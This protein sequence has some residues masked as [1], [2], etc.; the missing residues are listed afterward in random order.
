MSPNLLLLSAVLITCTFKGWAANPQ[1]SVLVSSTPVEEAVLTTPIPGFENHPDAFHSI[2]RKVFTDAGNSYR[3]NEIHFGAFPNVAQALWAQECLKELGYNPEGV[4]RFTSLPI[5][6]TD[7][8][9]FEA[10]RLFTTPDS[11][12]TPQK[13]A[14]IQVQ[15]AW[16]S[17][18]PIPALLAVSESLDAEAF[19]AAVSRARILAAFEMLKANPG[20]DG[21]DVA[22]AILNEVANGV[23]PAHVHDVAEA[24]YYLARI[25]HYR[26]D[27]RAKA[28]VAYGEA[29]DIAKNL[30]HPSSKY[31]YAQ[32][33]MEQCALDFEL[34]RRGK[35]SYD[36]CRANMEKVLNEL[37]NSV[38]EVRA[39]LELMR[40]ETFYFNQQYEET[41][42]AVERYL[43]KFPGYR[44]EGSMAA[45]YAGY[46]AAALENWSG[47]EQWF[48][49]ALEYDLKESEMFQWKG[50]LTNP[51]HEIASYMFQNAQSRG[52]D[53]KADQWRNLVE[54]QKAG[55][56]IESQ[57]VLNLIDN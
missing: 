32:S 55:Q 49:T 40:A 6:K 3:I 51:A 27:D 48:T 28:C 52:L 14:Y 33:I 12:P 16:D 17:A 41:I 22:V 4:N 10:M 1:Y 26:Y 44:T 21:I 56:T 7:C 23:V 47:M 25:W 45:S 19:P 53:G 57:S 37:G 13:A 34:A 15:E 2:T 35:G 18:D 46:S 42:L 30:T 50:R 11:Y 29:A 24:R 5:A 36:D 38:E 54:G 43:S 39:R 31:L 20:T 9:D 8:R